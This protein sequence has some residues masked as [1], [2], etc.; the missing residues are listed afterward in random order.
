MNGQM[1]FSFI[2]RETEKKIMQDTSQLW[3]QARDS[4]N[5]AFDITNSTAPVKCSEHRERAQR[6][7]ERERERQTPMQTNQM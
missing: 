6:G 3:P 5:S 4:G 1:R 2:E 7:P